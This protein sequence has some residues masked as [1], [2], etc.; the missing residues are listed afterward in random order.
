MRFEQVERA[1]LREEEARIASR[2][3]DLDISPGEE[4]LMFFTTIQLEEGAFVEVS[5]R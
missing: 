1:I 3:N 4:E 5:Y 2:L